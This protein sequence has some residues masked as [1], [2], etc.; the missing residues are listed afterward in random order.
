MLWFHSSNSSNFPEAS[1][2]FLTFLLK[3]DSPLEVLQIDNEKISTCHASIVIREA[4]KSLFF[5]LFFVLNLLFP[6]VVS[7]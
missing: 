4:T 1:L 2:A 3:V 6:R 5:R 7:S